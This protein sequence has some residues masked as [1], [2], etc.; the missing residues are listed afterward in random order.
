M[1][2]LLPVCLLGITG[3]LAFYP[4]DE[5]QDKITQALEQYSKRFPQE[6]VY[7]HLDKDYYAA[8][9]T[10]WFKAY[11]L[12]QGQ[13]SLS[14]TNLYVELVDKSGNVVSKKISFCRWCY[15]FGCIRT[16]G[17]FQSG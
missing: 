15:R 9:E 6:K 16:A 13:P 17:K 10:M 5:W 7:L 3:A 11:V 2:W 12:L 14:A 1:K 4:A 8:G